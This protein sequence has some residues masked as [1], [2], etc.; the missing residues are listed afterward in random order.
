MTSL[1]LL[2]RRKIQ[3]QLP[4]WWGSFLMDQIELK[5][6]CQ[7]NYWN[8]P[9]ELCSTDKEKLEDRTCWFMG[10]RNH[11]CILLREIT[12]KSRALIV[13]MQHQTYL[14]LYLSLIAFTKVFQQKAFHLLYAFLSNKPSSVKNSTFSKFELDPTISLITLTC[15]P[16]VWSIF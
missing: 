15:F 10:F 14:K 7:L 1:Q 3:L 6:K 4:L 16:G 2:Q 8:Y 9:P 12:K 13:Y 5:I 11:V